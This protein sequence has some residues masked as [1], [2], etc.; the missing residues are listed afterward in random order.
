MIINKGGTRGMKHL[1]M[2]L[3]LILLTIQSTHVSSSLSKKKVIQE[4]GKVSFDYCNPSRKIDVKL[5]NILPVP[6]EIGVDGKLDLE[7]TPSSKAPDQSVLKNITV[8][9]K[10]YRVQLNFV[11]KGL[12]YQKFL[13]LCDLV[14][15]YHDNNVVTLK[16]DILLERQ[17]DVGIYTTYIKIQNVTRNT[18]NVLNL[19][20]KFEQIVTNGWSDYV[21]A[22]VA[23]A[24]AAAASWQ[25]G[26]WVT[27]F[28]LPLITGYLIVGVVCGPYVCNLLTDYKIYLIGPQLN[29]L[30]LSFIAFAAGEEIY[31]PALKG[32]FRGILYQIVGVT[33]FTIFFIVIV[34][35]FTHNSLAS[36]WTEDMGEMCFLS[37]SFLLG[38]IMVAR[39]PATIVGT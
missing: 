35:L 8:L 22:I 39:S 1:S 24:I 18:N 15:S 5:L 27:V 34:F 6:L 31:F 3:V 37:V 28:D 11:K 33:V 10:G 7:I 16:S 26:Q 4:V 36:Q 19:C 23:F 25:L 9:C 14:N 38:I 29:N 2:L 30:S 12:T 13:P 17:L 32:L 21:S 20:L